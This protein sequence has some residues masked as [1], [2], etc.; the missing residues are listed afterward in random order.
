LIPTYCTPAAV[1]ALEGAQ[2]LASRDRAAEVQPLHLLLALLDE[3]EGR[4]AALFAAAGLSPAEARSALLDG[5]ALADASAATPPLGAL[6]EDIVS[7]AHELAADLSAER[8]IASEHLLLALLKKHEP[9]RSKLEQCGLRVAEIEAQIGTGAP[10]LRLD[11]PLCLAEPAEEIDTARI[12]DA[13]ANRAREALRVLEDYCRFSLDDRFLSGRL[14]QLRHDLAE[15]LT[16]L[17]S[18]WLLDGRD[19]QGDVGTE[20]S[21]RRE[22]ERYSLA[23][24]VQAN[25]KRLQEAFRSLEEYGKL[26]SPRLGQALEKLRYRSYTLERAL[27]AGSSSRQRLADTQLCVLVS[28]SLCK[29][30]MDWTIAEA[31]DGGAGMIQLR[32]KS[33]PDH[34][35]LERA[36]SVRAWTAKAGIL[37][38]VNDRPDIAKLA[39]ADG[40]HLG[41][42]D[43]SVKDARRIVGPGALIGVSTHNLDQARQAILDGANYIGVGP[44][45]PSG[46]KTFTD[47][48]GQQLLQQVAAETSIPAFAIGGV[49]LDTIDRAVAAGARRV[50][51]SQAICAADDPRS[52][53][54]G[55]KQALSGVGVRAINHGSHG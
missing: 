36:R 3:E 34:A 27:F 46:T 26:R 31:A 52:V 29:A 15:A 13:S 14:K 35:L 23:A 12:L 50:A 49:N 45:F 22:Q 21:T 42:E 5:I 1:R 7:H 40:V 33:L 19:T 16:I 41:Q 51:V 8:T 44:L 2:Q 11:E 10:S 9:L 43:L 32:E 54:A 18:G 28:G 55:L 17:P 38:I 6:I 25:W 53:A 4:A 47:F 37:F 39:E 20:L 24:V 48:P 30:S